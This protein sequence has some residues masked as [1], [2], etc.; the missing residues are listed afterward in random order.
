MANGAWRIVDV[1]D[2]AGIPSPETVVREINRHLS[3]CL[4]MVRF[5]PAQSR[6]LIAEEIIETERLIAAIRANLDALCF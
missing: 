6:Q 1:R 4:L 5:L 2:D 3:S